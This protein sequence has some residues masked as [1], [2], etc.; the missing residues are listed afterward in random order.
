[1]PDD[2]TS[3]VFTERGLF[4]SG[5]AGYPLCAGVISVPGVVISFLCDKPSSSPGDG[6]VVYGHLVLRFSGSVQRAH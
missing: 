3:L 1:M 6:V 2:D 5:S 4:L